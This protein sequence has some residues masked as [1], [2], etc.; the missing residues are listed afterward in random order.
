VYT[1]NAQVEQGNRNTLR[2]RCALPSPPL[3]GRYGMIP[4]AANAL[5]CIVSGEQNPQNCPFPLGFRHPAGERP[6]HSLR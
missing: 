5:Q 2:P 6:S 1:Q 3:P 4:F